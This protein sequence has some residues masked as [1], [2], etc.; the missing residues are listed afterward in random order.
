MKAKRSIERDSQ[1]VRGKHNNVTN[2]NVTVHTADSKSKRKPKV[3]PKAIEALNERA[4]QFNDLKQLAVSRNIA[5]PA[6]IGNLDIN[7]NEV[8]STKAVQNVTQVL[9]EKIN[10]M[11]ELVAEAMKD[12]AG[13]AYKM[14]DA[15]MEVRLE[16]ALRSPSPEQ[17]AMSETTA[18]ASPMKP[19][20]LPEQRRPLVYS[21]T[22]RD[23]SLDT[24]PEFTSQETGREM[25]R[26]LQSQTFNVTTQEDPAN[27][28]AR[29]NI[30]AYDEITPAQPLS[31]LT[32]VPT[33][34]AIQI[35][36]A[37]NTAIEDTQ[38]AVSQIEQDAQ[39]TLVK[40]DSLLETE[41]GTETP[42]QKALRNAIRFNTG[43]M[44][45]DTYNQFKHQVQ[46]EAICG[47]SLMGYRPGKDFY[48]DKQGNKIQSPSLGQSTIQDPNLPHSGIP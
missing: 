33:E 30:N 43:S 39:E 9:D 46:L 40:P 29:S 19:N 23:H 44:D 6:R 3:D 31:P 41:E 32:N 24:S 22:Y 12:N 10:D 8:Q 42:A 16:N 36:R 45:E 35:E 26:P 47:F 20:P 27:F 15:A 1:H 4:Q 28:V 13:L 17:S 14:A 7:P 38:Q 34:G 2:V 48:F 21:R 18:N 37:V 5:L 11:K 25:R